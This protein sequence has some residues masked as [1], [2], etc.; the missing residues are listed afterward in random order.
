M[1]LF[2]HIRCCLVIYIAVFI[3]YVAVWSYKLLYIVV[4]VLILLFWA[5]ILLIICMLLFLDEHKS[6]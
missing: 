4:L 2:G 1:L 3:I 5:Y 6:E